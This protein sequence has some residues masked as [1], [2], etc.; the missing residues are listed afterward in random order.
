MCELID[1][2]ITEVGSIATRLRPAV[3]DDLGL[4]DALEWYTT[5]FEKRTGLTCVFKHAPVPS[6]KEVMA[7]AIYRI[8]QEALTNVARHAQATHVDVNLNIN[9]GQLMLNVQ[10][11]GS[12]FDPNRLTEQEELGL[13]GMRERAYLIGG[14]LIIESVP[15]QGTNVQ[16]TLPLEGGAN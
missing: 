12:G 6:L 11:D 14:D 1:S 4:I 13:A 10:D 7:I 9:N 16:L 8:T 15:G 5:E 3:L 2:T